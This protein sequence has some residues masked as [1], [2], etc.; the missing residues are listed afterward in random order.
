MRSGLGPLSKKSVSRINGL[1]R[2]KNAI[3][4]G[5]NRDSTKRLEGA[6]GIDNAVKKET[7]TA[8]LAS[9]IKWIM[10]LKKKKVPE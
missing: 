7:I 6:N 10:I 8:Q 2:V 3:T 4:S 5:E 1:R 9:W